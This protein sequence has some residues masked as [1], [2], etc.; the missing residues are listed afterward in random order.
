[1]GNFQLALNMA[2]EDM[3]QAL[4]V[5]QQENNNMR[6]AFEHFQIGA[7]LA[8]QNPRGTVNQQ[9]LQLGPQPRVCLLEKFDGIQ[10]K[11]QGFVNQIW[12]IF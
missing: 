5:L 1:M 3:W 7:P 6:Q 10:S 12:L 9:V 8:T 4:H 11:F 2:M